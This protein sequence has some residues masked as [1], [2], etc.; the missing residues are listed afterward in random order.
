MLEKYSAVVQKKLC[1]VISFI[2]FPGDNIDVI[3]ACLL[4]VRELAYRLYLYPN[5]HT[6]ELLN[7]MLQGRHLLARLTG[8]QTYAERAL[9][10]T[11]AQTPGIIFQTK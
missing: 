6:E 11:L 4:Q 7:D 8:F 9:K 5:S 2:F 1:F 3:F 10:G